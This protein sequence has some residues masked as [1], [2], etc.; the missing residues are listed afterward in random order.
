MLRKRSPGPWQDEGPALDGEVGTG[1]AHADLDLASDV[2]NESMR[3]SK[4]AFATPRS[5]RLAPLHAFGVH[6]H[7]AAF[8]AYVL[9]VLRAKSFKLSPQN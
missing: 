1:H 2:R 4:S 5:S 3:C 8:I 9:Q 6:G 7:S